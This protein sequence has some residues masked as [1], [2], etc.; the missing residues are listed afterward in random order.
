MKTFYN[1][2]FYIS[3]CLGLTG[4]SS[5]QAQDTGSISGI[6]R[7]DQGD[8]LPNISVK[9]GNTDMA[10]LTDE[11]G[12]Y[13]FSGV[14][15]G[16]QTLVIF[17]GG[18][19]EVRQPVQVTAG[20]TTEMNIGLTIKSVELSEVEIVGNA[21]AFSP[22]V[23][24]GATKLPVSYEVL[25]LSAS[26]IPS[27]LIT[28]RQFT[29]PKDA[30]RMIGSI[31]AASGGHSS[32]HDVYSARGFSISSS[33]GGV[34]KDGLYYAGFDSPPADVASLERIEY[35]KGASSIL[36]G[37]AEPGGLINYVYKK[38]LNE[39]AYSINLLGGSWNT[40]RGTLDAGG[41][42]V[43]D[44]LLYR[45]TLGYEDS[46][47]W[48]D[49]S[50]TQ[51]LA[52]MV[53]LQY[54]ISPRTTLKLTAEIISQEANP[55]NADAPVVA[56]TT[57]DGNGS[58]FETSDSWFAGFANDFVEELTQVYQASLRHEFSDQLNV[59][60]GFSWNRAEK[61]QG[62]TGYFL[63]P[64]DPVT[65]D[66][67]RLVFDQKRD[68]ETWATTVD[69]NYNFNTGALSHKLLVG[70]S[71]ANI[72]SRNI[73]GFSIVVQGVQAALLNAGI[74][75]DL[76]DPVPPTNVDTPRNPDFNHRRNYF[77]PLGWAQLYWN[78]Q[79]LGIYAQNLTTIEGT[80]LSFLLAFRYNNYNYENT[81]NNGHAGTDADLR[82]PYENTS[83]VPRL[84][85]IYEFTPGLSAYASF[86]QSV[87]PIAPFSPDGSIINDD[88]EPIRGEQI[89]FGIKGKVNNLFTYTLSFYNLD[90]ENE[91]VSIS[92]TESTQDGL[93]RSRGIELDIS[94]SPV[95]G[96]NFYA[97]Y[98]FTDTEI[99]ESGI[100][101]DLEGQPANG[102]PQHNLALW[103]TYT[104]KNNLGFGL[105][106]ESRSEWQLSPTPPFLPF[107]VKEDG[108]FIV[109]ASAF[110]QVK[111]KGGAL[112][113]NATVNNIFDDYYFQPSTSPVFVKRGAPVGFT[114]S[115]G[116]SWK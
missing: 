104:F 40:F 111:T 69:V 116:Y 100:S 61:E 76:V 51:R 70:G 55:S 90:R 102:I 9:L 72:D 83:F 38:P 14:P 16:V 45:A 24:T 58:F 82:D 63:A 30:I 93:R 99:I 8:I 59:T 27:E 19:L 67:N 84:G 21:G 86:S 60:A 98:A 115:I 109:N 50:F 46:E 12:K 2:V 33:R 42:I 57:P 97:S 107:T 79:E 110:Y 54:N 7:G 44:K 74:E 87:N 20:Q 64:P 65:G 113:F 94:G 4:M 22:D 66:L 1:L 62:V 103:N 73:N 37:S 17:G 3:L 31:T 80:G 49:F 77:D 41:P 52:P 43:K 101:E 11:Q 10:T 53:S 32:T 15:A 114:V 28:S 18:Y 88:P 25:P 78:E 75:V 39:A 48:Q 68:L 85:V 34:L 5:L 26:V 95:R 96:Y 81:F 108:Y 112:D 29:R 35:I 56:P 71:Y 23:I 89:E 106:V 13:M 47:T 92:P 105:G 6:V 91:V 36:F